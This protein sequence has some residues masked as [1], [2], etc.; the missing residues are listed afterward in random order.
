M[1]IIAGGTMEPIDEL[2]ALTDKW[3]DQIVVK[4]YEHIIKKDQCKI[5]L[6]RNFNKKEIFFNHQTMSRSDAL[7]YF[8]PICT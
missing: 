8:R 2:L 1:T 6:V 7:E 3:K 5:Y 4:K